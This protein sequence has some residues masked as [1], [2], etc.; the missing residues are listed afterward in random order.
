MYAIVLTFD[1]QI[2]FA[3]LVIRSYSKL[4]KSHP[5]IFRVPYNEVFPDSLSARSDVELI[6][7]AKDIRSTMS[8]LLLGIDDDEFV[9]W[10]IDDRYPVQIR[11]F[12]GLERIV[13]FISENPASVDEI[14]LTNHGREI[15]GREVQATFGST[16]FRLQIEGK[17]LGF[18]MHH[19]VRAK[20]LRK[21][22][23]GFELPDRY[24]IYQVTEKL[25]QEKVTETI[26]M[27][28]RSLIHFGEPCRRGKM[29][30][31]AL[32][33]LRKYNIEVPNIEQGN[34][35]LVYGDRGEVIYNWR[36][37]LERVRLRLERKL[38]E[39]WGLS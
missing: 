30:I 5:F 4:W 3:Q 15:C 14:K 38:G 35:V 22:F 8:N 32:Q 24:T 16:Q 26:L 31:N 2:P 1:R 17:P 27:P 33:D 34:Q 13:A 12:C 10:T 6:H 25:A 29:T 20:V 39:L 11:D 36:Y 37:K 18:Y 9:F 28:E 23:L 19:F 7:T 21:H